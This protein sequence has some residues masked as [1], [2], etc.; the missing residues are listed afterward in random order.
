MH[1][2]QLFCLSV[3]KISKFH[4]S[5]FQ[6]EFHPV[7][8]TLL[9]RHGKKLLTVIGSVIL[10]LF[11]DFLRIQEPPTRPTDPSDKKEGREI[12]SFEGNLNKLNGLPIYVSNSESPKLYVFYRALKHP[13]YA[14]NASLKV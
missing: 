2:S 5:R 12:D 14:Q 1:R 9:L 10:V 4:S 11:S 8:G 13:Y 7:S 3:V 6:F